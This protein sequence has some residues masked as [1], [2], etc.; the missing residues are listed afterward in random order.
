[1]DFSILQKWDTHRIARMQPFATRHKQNH[2]LQFLKALKLNRDELFPEYHMH[3][4]ICC[5]DNKKVLEF[6]LFKT[7]Y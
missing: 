3:A 2:G 7:D 6:H 1:M 4:I 5:S